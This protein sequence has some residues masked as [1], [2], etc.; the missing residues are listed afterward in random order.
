[1]PTLLKLFFGD[2]VPPPTS[3]AHV[4]DL[5]GRFTADLQRYEGTEA[6]LLH[7]YQHYPALP[8]WVMLLHYGRDEARMIV[9]WCDETSQVLQQMQA[10]ETGTSIVKQPGKATKKG[11]THAS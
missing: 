8:Y 7:T 11:V 10:K 9:N 6:H 5:H 3:L 1:M 2:S 4:Q